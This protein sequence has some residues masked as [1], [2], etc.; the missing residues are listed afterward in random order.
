M[1][2]VQI[3]RAKLTGNAS[4]LAIVPLAR[5]YGGV[6]PQGTALPCIGITEVSSVDRNT[7]SGESVIH[8]TERIQVTV[9]TADYVKQK[10]LMALIRSACRNF[11]GTVGSITGVSIHTDSKGPDFSDPEAGFCMQTQDFRV[12]FNEA[13]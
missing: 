7:L 5:I 10:A 9:M 2:G 4:V 12:G 1:S 3:V 13:A 6:V 8:V 11:V